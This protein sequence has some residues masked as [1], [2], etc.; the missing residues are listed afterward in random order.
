MTKFHQKGLL[1][2]NFAYK[3]CNAYRQKNTVKNVKIIRLRGNHG[4]PHAKLLI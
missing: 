4:A 1:E 3:V 2:T